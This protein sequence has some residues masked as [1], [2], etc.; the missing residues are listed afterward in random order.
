MQSG[1]RIP[2]V[3]VCGE[4][5]GVL[6]SAAGVIAHLAILDPAAFTLVEALAEKPHPAVSFVVAGVELYLPLAGMVDSSEERARLEKELAEIAGQIQRLEALL[7]GSFAEKAPAAVVE[8]ERQKLATYRETVA[9]LEG[10]IN[11]L[12]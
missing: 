6:R 11:S 12:G 5:L 10:R 7:G 1:K 9:R 8:R 2:A 4:R 3:L